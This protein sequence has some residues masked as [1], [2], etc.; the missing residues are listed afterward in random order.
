MIGLFI[1]K[2][3]YAGKF[4]WSIVHSG[5]CKMDEDMRLQEFAEEKW[6]AK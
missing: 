2:I 3:Y 5:F 6:K 4:Q 1:I